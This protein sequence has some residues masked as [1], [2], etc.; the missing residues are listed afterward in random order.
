MAEI[1]AIIY[2]QF[3]FGPLYILTTLGLS[4][5]IYF[6]VKGSIQEEDADIIYNNSYQFLVGAFIAWIVLFVFHANTDLLHYVTIS[7]ISDLFLV[8]KG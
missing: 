1:K 2:Q 7:P 4:G 5:C 3:Y 6:L 8:P